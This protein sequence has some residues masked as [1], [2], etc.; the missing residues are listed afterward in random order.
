MLATIGLATT[1]AVAG[2]AT[3]GI[4]D[5]HGAAPRSAAAAAGV[6]AVDVPIRRLTPGQSAR[7]VKLSRLCAH[8]T[9]ERHLSKRQIRKVFARYRLGYAPSRYVI[10]YLVPASLGG[11]NRLRNLWPEPRGG[12][13]GASA[14]NELE[15]I[16]RGRVCRR[17]MSL[18]AARSAISTSW[19][20]AYRRYVGTLAPATTGSGGGG[21]RADVPVPSTGAYWGAYV[22]SGVGSVTGTEA[23]VGRRF[24][25][26]HFYHDWFQR[27]G[28][29]DASE[30]ALADAGRIIFDSVT[31]RNYN[32]GAIVKWAKVADGSQDARIDQLARYAISL[33]HPMFVSF[34]VEPETDIGTYGTAADYVAAFRHLVQ[35]FR[36]DRADNVS[37]VWQVEGWS[38]WYTTYLSLYPGDSVV[39]WIGWDPYNWASCR[40]AKWQSFAS[41]VQPFYNWLRAHGHAGTPLMLSEYGTV[42]A[43]DGGTAKGKWFTDGAAAMKRFP[44]LKAVVAFDSTR[45]CPWRV[46]SSSASLHGFADM[47]N[48]PYFHP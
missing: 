6:P 10:D 14:K 43:G 29:A 28:G 32:T 41:I 39:D 25:I 16:L 30:K 22:D 11:S 24:G 3:A 40:G 18:R 12:Y 8:K 31:P 45:D 27:W 35:R 47:G 5:A 15:A 7:H 36:A 13:A 19:P 34:H 42:E 2:A 33:G 20:A 37:F 17:L 26:V 23:Q 38:D 44:Q 48:N 21:G 46:D 1:L 9:T 4:G